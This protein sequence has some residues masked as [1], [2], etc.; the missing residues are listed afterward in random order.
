MNMYGDLVIS[1]NGKVGVKPELAS[2]VLLHNSLTLIWGLSLN[3][4]LSWWP[5]NPREP[6]VSECA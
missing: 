2:E 6:P 1:M 3:L 4:K 5:T